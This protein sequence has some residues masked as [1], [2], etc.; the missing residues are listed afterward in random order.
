[1]VGSVVSSRKLVEKQTRHNA[2][3][4]LVFG[5]LSIV[6][7]SRRRIPH[8]TGSLLKQKRIGASVRRAVDG[9][10]LNVGTPGCTRRKSEEKER[11]KRRRGVSE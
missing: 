9:V 11:K 4:E 7:G 8:S 2:T 1:V 10:A 3:H 5:I 6:T